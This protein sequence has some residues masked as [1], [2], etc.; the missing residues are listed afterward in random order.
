MGCRRPDPLLG[1][2]VG[3]RHPQPG[4]R[5]AMRGVHR[6]QRGEDRPG[7]EQDPRPHPPPDQG[8]GLRTRR[9]RP[10]RPQRES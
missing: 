5:A 2:V 10:Q 7:P 3:R 6:G 1:Q 9:R 8:A 4:V